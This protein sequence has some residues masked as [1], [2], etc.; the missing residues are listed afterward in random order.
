MNLSRVKEAILHFCLPSVCFCCSN[1]LPFGYKEPLCQRCLMDLFYIKLP[2]CKKCGIY[3]E[4][5]GE[6]CHPCLNKKYKFDFSRSVFM[7]NDEISSVISA[8]KYKKMDWLSDWFSLK[9]LKKFE[10]YPEF[11]GYDSLIYIPISA[12]K[13]RKRGFNQTYLIAK[14]LSSMLGLEIIEEAVIKKKDARNQ[15]GL[16]AQ[17]RASNIKDSF[18]LV[19]HSRINKKNIIIIDDVATTMSTIDEMAGVLKSDGAK[20]VSAYTIARE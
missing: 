6:V 12:K 10:D 16:D 11:F 4:N 14:K 17:E 15:V 1:D 2:Y 3:L 8:Y 19:N 13:M 9:M 5:G 7:Y 18:E 20:K